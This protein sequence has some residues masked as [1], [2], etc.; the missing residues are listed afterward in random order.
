MAKKPTLYA[1]LGLLRSATQEEVRRAYL[2][3]AKRLHP[4]TNNAPGE[5]ELFL[6]IQ[7][8]YQILSEP[9]RRSAYDAKLEPEEELPPFVNQRVLFSR[10]EISRLKEAQLV[11]V[12]LD[13][14][15]HEKQ[16]ENASAPL[17]VC[18]ML[19]CSTSM[20]G[21]K[22]DTVKG[23][24][25]QL[26]QR[27]K[28]Q[29]IFSIV[30][31]SDRA[32]VVLPA[33]RQM[34][35]QRSENRI[36]MLQTSGGT[37]ILRGLEAGYEEVRRYASPHSINHIILLTDGRTYGDEQ[38][39]YELA[40]HAAEEG[41]GISGLGIGSGWNDIFLD[42]LANITGGSSM[43]VSQPKDIERLLNEKFSNLSQAYAENVTLEFQ[44][45]ENVEINYLFRLYPETGP[46][47]SENPIHLGPIL[48]NELLSVLIEFRIESQQN[49]APD[50]VNLLRGQ[51]EISSA[52]AQ[53]P[54]PPIRINLSLGLKDTPA[55]EPPPAAIIHAIS[56]LTL[57]RI[58]E[59]ARTEVAAGEYDKATSHLQKLAAHLLAQGQHNLA[60]TIMLEA[61]HIEKEKSFTESGEKQ[62]KYGTRALLLPGETL[63]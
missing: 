15:P 47:I 49:T 2:K 52:L 54:I 41:I 6:D 5:T 16:K 40:Q 17:N 38:A 19:D 61:E 36:H 13:L 51:L 53:T 14:S 18:L 35:L 55:P 33:T 43:F 7:Q 28:A 37:E 46:L 8:A 56:K 58:Q 42:H 11:Y 20:K 1:L 31:F 59:K 26:M 39:C 34:N 24:A 9:A 22:L 62:I 21:E 25:I 32:E 23:T 44:A 4:D 10:K 30:S 60:H 27:L 48:H 12:L 3:A 50:A 29:D 45:Q 63:Q 57:Y